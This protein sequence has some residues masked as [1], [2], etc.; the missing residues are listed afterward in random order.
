MVKD[1]EFDVIIAGGGVAGA[2][3]AIRCRQSG[4]R[5]LMITGNLN[6]LDVLFQTTPSE[7]VHP[8]AETLLNALG[9]FNLLAASC[10]GRY[11]GIATGNSVNFLGSDAH[12][13]WQGYH[14]DKP[15]FVKGLIA[16][17][18]LSGTETL[19]NEKI[20]SLALGNGGRMVVKVSA[21]ITYQARYLIDASGHSQIAGKI[22]NLKKSFYSPVLYCWTG[23]TSGISDDVFSQLHTSFDMTRHGW[24]WLA[25]E[26]HQYCTWT[27]VSTLRNAHRPISPVAGN[28]FQSVHRNMRWRLYDKLAYEGII[29]CGDAA[30]ILDPASGQGL[31]MALMSGI[32]AAECVKLAFYSGRQTASIAKD[33][34]DWF[35]GF[36]LKKMELLRSYYVHNGIFDD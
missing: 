33:Y 28:S 10:R 27:T 11:D 17:A 26:D 18:L 9:A 6:P 30:G 31:L 2:A 35:K 19:S 3:T 13:K 8:G 1:N 16:A 20:T 22:L 29:L 32:Q 36:Y 14:L 5:C 7:S 25:P 21:G 15:L 23:L 24:Q 12:G 34:T 4:L